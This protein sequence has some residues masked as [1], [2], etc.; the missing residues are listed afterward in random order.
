VQIELPADPADLVHEEEPGVTCL[1]V[2]VLEVERF[3]PS[4]LR[5]SLVT[6]PRTVAEQEQ[7]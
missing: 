4:E 2:E 7:P 1:H 6:A 3:V 5:V